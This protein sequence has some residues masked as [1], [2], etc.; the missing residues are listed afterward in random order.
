M[1]QRWRLLGFPGTGGRGQAR[2]LPPAPLQT[3]LVSGTQLWGQCGPLPKSSQHGE[4]DG[5]TQVGRVRSRMGSAGC[6]LFRG[7][8]L[9][10]LC[11]RDPNMLLRPDDVVAP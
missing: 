11:P 9:L 1:S 7:S 4:G 8:L 10:D 6:Q 5:R 3:L 2:P